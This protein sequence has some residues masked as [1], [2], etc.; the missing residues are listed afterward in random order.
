MKVSRA[1]A[2]H[3]S[4]FSLL[5]KVSAFE[6]HLDKVGMHLCCFFTRNWEASPLFPKER[7]ESNSR[8]REQSPFLYFAWED[9]VPE[10]W[11]KNLEGGR[12]LKSI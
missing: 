10:P 12:V 6:L 4:C 11:K 9:D 8:A 1:L 2:S 7:E 3:F 5:Y